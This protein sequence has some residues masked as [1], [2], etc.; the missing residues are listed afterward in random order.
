M[1]NA[2]E[3]Q[4]GN[5]SRLE[6]AFHHAVAKKQFEEALRAMDLDFKSATEAVEKLRLQKVE[7][8]GRCSDLLDRLS[9]VEVAVQARGK[10]RG[11]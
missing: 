5:A 8:D 10:R 4:R 2:E 3:T 7:A 11:K 9:R 1:S 6:E